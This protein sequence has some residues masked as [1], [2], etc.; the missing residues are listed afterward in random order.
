MQTSYSFRPTLLDVDVLDSL[1]KAKTEDKR[2]KYLSKSRERSI[3]KEEICLTKEK[4]TYKSE[5]VQY[6]GIKIKY[7]KNVYFRNEGVHI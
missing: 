6:F 4:D 3:R 1:T 7:Y 2:P 5:K